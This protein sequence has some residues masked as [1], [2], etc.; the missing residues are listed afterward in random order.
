M[1]VVGLLGAAVPGLVGMVSSSKVR[2][3][4]A[5]GRMVKVSENLGRPYRLVAVLPLSQLQ[6]SESA[7]IGGFAMR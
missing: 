1:S 6:I 7:E 5:A 2:E 4:L 3:A